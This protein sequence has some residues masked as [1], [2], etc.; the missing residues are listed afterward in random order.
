MLLISLNWLVIIVSKF[1]W[2]WGRVEEDDVAAF[3]SLVATN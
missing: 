3:Q 2:I 1:K